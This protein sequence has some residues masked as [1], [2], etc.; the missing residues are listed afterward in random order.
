ME[1]SKNEEYKEVI[2]NQEPAPTYQ[3]IA[4]KLEYAMGL[5]NLNSK[6]YKP[7]KFQKKIRSQEEDNDFCETNE[8][9]FNKFIELFDTI[10]K[11]ANPIKW[12]K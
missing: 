6:P 2:F 10:N 12:F 3:D 1:E 11:L 9:F 4:K 8:E 5:S 7:T